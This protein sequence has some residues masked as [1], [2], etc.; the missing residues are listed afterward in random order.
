[1]A[2]STSNWRG[3]KGNP[4][5]N[6]QIYRI[7]EPEPWRG[8]IMLSRWALPFINLQQH[9]KDFVR[10]VLN[11]FKKYHLLIVVAIVV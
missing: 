2:A 4:T 8:E 6:F 10:I 9:V 1:M 5:T 11:L 3:S 7:D